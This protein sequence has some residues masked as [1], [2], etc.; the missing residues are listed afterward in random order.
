MVGFYKDIELGQPADIENKL[1]EKERELEGTRKSG[2]PDDMY[3]L[4]NAEPARG[5]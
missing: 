3:T 4:L 5:K 1:E 2:R